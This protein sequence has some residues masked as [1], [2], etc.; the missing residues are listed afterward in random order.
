MKQ[1]AFLAI[2]GAMGTVSRFGLAAVV[3]RLCGDRFPWG[4]V[5]VNLLGCFLFGLVW[6][7]AEEK[8]ILSPQTRFVLLTGFM[9]A[10]TTFS[11]FAFET[12]AL[13]QA[14]SGWSA[15]GNLL[16]QNGLGIVCVI[17]GLAA[18]RLL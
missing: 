14:G 12:T 6:T 13:L 10:F 17:A 15:A 4:T 11:T 8:L 7:L 2:A 3:Q 16:L 5:A 18:G 9:G 1:L